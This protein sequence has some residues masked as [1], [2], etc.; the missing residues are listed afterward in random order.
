MEIVMA[1]FAFAQGTPT[2][3]QDEQSDNYLTS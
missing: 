1:F 3:R 2:V